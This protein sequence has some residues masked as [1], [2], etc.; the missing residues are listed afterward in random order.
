[1]T[2]IVKNLIIINVV[3]FLVSN[4]IYP[5]LNNYLA[6]YYP[7]NPEFRPY[8]LVTHMFAHASFSHIL[9][10]MF[11]LWNFG[12]IIEQVL[13][14]KRFFTLYFVSGFGA[15]FLHLLINGLM[16]YHQ[17]GT[18]NLQLTDFISAEGLHLL[19]NN[20]PFDDVN[21]YVKNPFLRDQYFSM[22]LGASGAIYGVTAAFAYLFPNT[23]LMLILFP[24]PIKAKYLIPGILILYDLGYGSF[25]NS[26][27]AHF[28]HIGGAIFGFCL[29]FYWNKTNKTT[30]Y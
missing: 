1:M 16:I 12:N 4:F 20:L 22:M 19:S 15:I 9:F 23:E 24:V 3:V 13:G 2:P 7:S 17:I 14:S 11:A 21:A 25:V 10:N 6:I 30:F 29:V 26:G 18:F 28:A 8:Q 5:D 27:V